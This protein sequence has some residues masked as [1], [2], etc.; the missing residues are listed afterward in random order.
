M[1]LKI[2]LMTVVMIALLPIT[3]VQGMDY[4]SEIEKQ[5]RNGTTT[6]ADQ[7]VSDH[8][9]MWLRDW[10]YTNRGSF[11][12]RVLHGVPMGRTDPANDQEKIEFFYCAC[13]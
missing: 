10:N 1:K 9:R 3:V 4:S 12:W 11:M 2:S 13:G 7:I 6:T 8:P 5:I